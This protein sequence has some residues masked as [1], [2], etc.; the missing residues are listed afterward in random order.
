[1]EEENKIHEIKIWPEYYER[2]INKQKT[3]EVRKNDRDYQV[4][5]ILKMRLYYPQTKETV[6]SYILSQITYLLNG[7]QFGIKKGYCIMSIEILE[8][9]YSND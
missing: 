9:G 6:G 2:V 3:F 5:D 8:Y 1:M 4:G 7:G